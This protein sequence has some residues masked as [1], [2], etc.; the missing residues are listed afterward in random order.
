MKAVLFSVVL[1]AFCAALNA[2]PKSAFRPR[3][4]HPLTLE[5][6]QTPSLLSYRDTV[7]VLAVMVD[8][9]VSNDPRITGTGK[10][11]LDDGPKLI[12]SPPHDENYFSYKMEF[13]QNYFRK[14][15]NGK[16]TVTWYILPT[17]V[18]APKQMQLYASTSPGDYSGL[19]QLVVDSWEAADSAF[20]GFPFG[21]YDAFVVFH[22]GVGHDLNMVS[23]LGYDPAPLNLPSLYF[24][25]QT[26]KDA[27]Q[28]QTYGGIAV[29]GGSF[30]IDN[31]I[32]LPETETQFYV[33]GLSEQDTLQIGM[34][35]IFAASIGSYLG[36]PDLWN[37]STGGT[38]IGQ[39]GLEDGA[40][41]FAYYGLFPPE[42]SAWEKI[43]LGW[44]TPIVI[45][46][47][48]ENIPIP[49]VSLY[50]LGSSFSGQDTVYKV[51]INSHE[52]FLVENRSRD[53]LGTGQ[54]LKIMQ[55]GS[56]VT[57]TFSVD[58]TGFNYDDISSVTG[59]VV[60][61]QNYD[62]AL[63]GYS[64]TSPVIDGS[65]IFIWHI[66]D[67]II[68]AALPTNAVNAG[69]VRGIY[70]EEAKGAQDIGQTYSFLDPGSASEYGDPRD[71]W[72][73]DNPSST[74]TNTFDR[75]SFPNS[76]ANSGAYSLVTIKDF[77]ARM[78]RMTFSVQLG[79]SYLRPIAGF[80]K[81]LGPSFTDKSVQV[82]SNGIYVSKGD[83]VF[84][85]R[86][87]GTSGVPDAGGLLA[88][89][90]GSFPL[91]FD[92]T[93]PSPYFVGA[94]DSSLLLFKVID[95]NGDGTYD[96]VE[97]SSLNIGHRITAG[98][99]LS[100]TN[101]LVGHAD[102]GVIQAD[103]MTGQTNTI[104]SG[105]SD[106]VTA[107]VFSDC[108]VT[109]SAVQDASNHTFS[110]S[111]PFSG[112]AVGK[113]STVFLVDTVQRSLTVL[114]RDLT[115][116]GQTSLGSWSGPVT[117][118]VATD[119]NHSGH[120]DVVMTI[121]STVVGF[122]SSGFMLDGFPIQPASAMNH[123]SPVLLAKLT[124]DGSTSVAT[125][126]AA[127]IVSAYTNQGQKLDGF[128]FDIGTSVGGAPVAFPVSGTSGPPQVGFSVFGDNGML[129]A[130]Q[131]SVA[132]ASVDSG[133]TTPL[134]ADFFP[135]SRVYNWPNP[136]YGSS[137]Q[138][139]FY[140]SEDANIAITIFDI[141]GRK[142][143]D[144]NGRAVGGT[145][146][147]V[148][149]DVSHIQSGVYLARVEAS[150]QNQTQARIIKIAIVK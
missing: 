89:N 77:S 19:A 36:L 34:N 39:Y 53:P 143:T 100:G 120:E 127:G 24:G 15:S 81:N 63:L 99:T 149:W 16:V 86:S 98:P 139:R 9:P 102:G 126:D 82:W 136:V 109:K 32:V 35:G 8:F 96:S 13:V 130:Y 20:P 147:E 97:T 73:V 133:Q 145:D 80:P 106:P 90:G 128:P 50:H 45:S 64:S 94:K 65:G 30:K 131:L 144:L 118:P 138:I 29:S 6:A 108:A 28:D 60:D 107:V 33:N 22:A 137:T 66:D 7:R 43:W 104:I 141:A 148:R 79:D 11:M 103:P 18:T 119:F 85:F 71:A 3:L 117:M 52:Y 26:F 110:F 75:S 48:T 116:H 78:P 129:Y 93:L 122:N 55:N 54:T 111:T 95:D 21:Q 2:Q 40:S 134:S 47:T 5:H 58:A 56:T 113:G 135:A 49:A 38:E 27:F 70:L 61:V 68:N 87:D 76:N 10:F 59:S 125:V 41:F 23:L 37:T 91:V 31:T 88:A 74:Y 124:S 17:V 114:A 25:L 69:P 112:F 132:Y 12:D 140:C 101:V 123:A 72:F 14:V 1:F 84:V 150:N 121:G 57:E 67:D 62:W 92:P 146:T 4:S 44:V 105:L 142:I 115:V 46:S 42:P 83:S 51:P